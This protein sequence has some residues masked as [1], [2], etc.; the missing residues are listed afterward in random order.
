MRISDWSSDVCSSDL[1]V[2]EAVTDR[3]RGA[4]AA[5]ARRLIKNDLTL[6][7]DPFSFQWVYRH[8]WSGLAD[9][10][11]VNLALAGLIDLGRSEARRVGKECVSS[12]RSR[13]SAYP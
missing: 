9:R 6:F 11:D 10:D 12:C 5:L 3:Q 2:Y 4:T 7:P 13:W 1:R 8:K